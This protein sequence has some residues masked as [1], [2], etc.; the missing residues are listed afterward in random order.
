MTSTVS[1]KG[2][3]FTS[4]TT[5][6]KRANVFLDKLDIFKLTR[7]DGIHIGVLTEVAEVIA[8]PLA[9]VLQNLWRSDD[10]PKN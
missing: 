6:H 3:S 4:F 10:V 5:L 2:R 9:T 1:I 7:C 8:K